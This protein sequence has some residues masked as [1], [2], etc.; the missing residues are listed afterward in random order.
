VKLVAVAIVRDEA[1]VIEYTI[2]HL[3]AHGIE[4]ILVSDHLS[5]DGTSDILID[6]SKKYPVHYTAYTSEGF[7][8]ADE[9][10][11]LI[12][13]AKTYYGA[14]IVIPFDADELFVTSDNRRLLDLLVNVPDEIDVIQASVVNHIATC[15]DDY[16]ELNP[17]I[18]MKRHPINNEWPWPKVIVRP[19]QGM[20]VSAG[21]HRALSGNA[22]S[23]NQI[24]VR[25]YPYR[26]EEQFIKKIRN[27]YDG[28]SKTGLPHKIGSAIRD[29]GL[30]LKE[31][32]EDSVLRFYRDNLFADETKLDQTV[33]DPANYK[34]MIGG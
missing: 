5:E 20:R 33:E 18:R 12:E 29:L 17:F 6:L 26:S 11:R 28:L 23:T 16:S 21:N 24:E 9:T 15:V 8:Q 19:I 34:E 27:G 2:K 32:G 3:L 30:M 4:Q 10:N 25:H 14:D 31:E 7:Y 13:L 22:A 1:D